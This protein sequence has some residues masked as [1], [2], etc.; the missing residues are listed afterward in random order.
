MRSLARVGSL[1]GISPG[2]RPGTMAA[3]GFTLV[4][5]MVALLVVCVGMLGIA[6]LQGQALVAV[7][8]AIRRSTA[9][10]LAGNMA[11]RIRANRTAGPAYAAAPPA[12][13]C[14]DGTPGASCTPAQL[15][16]LDLADWTAVL[17]RALP[18]GR[19][20]VAV[21]AA[22]HPV[23]YTIAVSWDEPTRDAPVTYSLSMRLQAF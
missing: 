1:S 20:R 5:T 16:A 19:G 7:G 22:R 6:A 9:I 21:D 13:S 11:E 12:Q 3:T 23:G 8:T 10:D 18:H 14:A 15:A 17:A 2:E 4:E